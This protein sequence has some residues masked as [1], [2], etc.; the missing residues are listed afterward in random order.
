M[1][2]GNSIHMVLVKK[3]VLKSLAIPISVPLFGHNKTIRGFVLLPVLSGLIVLIFSLLIGPFEQTYLR[4][5]MIGICI[6][7][8]FLIAEL[9]NSFVKRKL[10]I[11]NGEYSKNH[12]YIQLIVDRADSLIGI[13][14]FYYCVTNIS[15]TDSFILFFS[16]M[17]LSYFTSFILVKL[18]I[19]KGI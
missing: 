5:V 7:Y 10:G 14:I 3:G 11:K 8:A 17:F 16:A 6:G 9:P 13:F 4:D 18:K 19:K 1:I 12:K 15:I 2:L